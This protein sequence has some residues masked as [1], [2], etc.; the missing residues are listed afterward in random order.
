MPSTANYDQQRIASKELWKKIPGWDE[1]CAHLGDQPTFGD[2]EIDEILIKRNA[3]SHI[4]VYIYN[5]R[6]DETVRY[7]LV[8][9]YFAN[10]VDLQLD[11]ITPQNVIGEIILRNGFEREE[12][13]GF[14][15]GQMPDDWDLTIEPCFGTD[16]WLRVQGLSIAFEPAQPSD[17]IMNR[18]T[19]TRG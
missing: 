18:I 13:I 19:S 6:S 15:V 14:T 3:P 10:V 8:T 5:G 7:A 17:M 1:L 2:G 16:G 9:L 4:C 12:R 11:G